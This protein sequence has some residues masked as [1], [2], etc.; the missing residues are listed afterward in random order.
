MVELVDT[1]DLKSLFSNGVRVQVP[2]SAKQYIRYK[3]TKP[4]FLFHKIKPALLHTPT[5]NNPRTRDGSYRVR[6]IEF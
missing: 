3:T 4:D 1:R 6:F 2:L 5:S